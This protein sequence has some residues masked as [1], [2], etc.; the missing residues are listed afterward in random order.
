MRKCLYA[1]LVLA[2]WRNSPA[3]EILP[4]GHRPVP[5]GVH[6]FTGAR[7]VVKPGEVIEE[8]TLVIRDGFVAAVGK[9]LTPPADARVWNMKG[10]TIYAGLIDPF[11]TMAGSNP[12]VSTA[13]SEP[14]DEEADRALTSGAGL[15]FFGV[16]G[17]EADPG[18]R[19]PG[20]QLES[21]QPQRRVAETYT[22]NARVLE[23]MHELGFTAANIVPESGIVRGQSALVALSPM[24]PNEALIKAD[25]FQHVAFSSDEGREAGYPRS[26]M[27]A[28]AAIRQVMFD[29]DFYAKDQEHYRQQ[30]NGRKRPT[31]NP[32]LEA[33]AP[34]ITKRMPVVLEGGSVLM[35]YR[36]TQLAADLNLDRIILASGQEWRR[37]DLFQGSRDSFIVP[38]HF[39]E[40][41]KLPEEDDWDQVS[42]DQLRAWDWGPSNPSLLRKQKRDIALTTYGL[43][44]KKQF[45][46][47]LRLVVDRGLSEDDALAALTTIPARL[48]G[49]DKQLGT[50]EAGKIA[51][52]TIV[53]GTNYFQPD[54]RIRE[55]WIDGRMYPNKPA[56]VADKDRGD[57]D[58]GDKDKAE[59]AEKKPTATN[60][61][62]TLKTDPKS[63]LIRSERLAR[64]PLEGRGPFA[65]PPA[66]LVKGATV[67][68][69]GPQGILAD[70]DVIFAGGRI[71]AI[72]KNLSSDGVVIDGKGKHVT[73]GLLDAHNHSMIL[74][75]VNEGSLPS[76]AMVRVQ[77]V[78]NSETANI[79]RQLAGGLTIANLLH[80]SAN[81]IGGQ[82]CIIKLRD[83]ASPDEL[84]FAEAPPGIKFA[85]GENVKQSSSERSTRFPRSRMGVG[86][87][88][89]NRFAAAQQY[90]EE[91]ANANGR[92]VRRDLE[93]ETLGEILKGKRWIHCHSYRQD[94]ILAFLRVMEGFNV[95]VGTLQHVLEGYKVADEIAQHGAGASCFADWWAYKYEVI[96]AIPYAGSLMRDRGV[97]VSFN[98]DSSDHARRLYL[99]AAKAVKYGGTTEEEALKFVTINPA[100]QLRIDQR[101]GSLEVGKDADFVLWS[102]SPLD[103]KTV[104]LQTWIDGRKFFDREENV[105]RVAALEKERDDLIDKAKQIL[106]NPGR[107]GGASDPKAEASFFQ[108]ALEYQH[109]FHDRHCLDEED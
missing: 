33:L 103:A 35:S 109:D 3:A 76:T 29:A 62:D 63:R 41:A 81:P 10:L 14:I 94:E 104:C 15:N 73:P 69:C 98:S 77:D 31:F 28:I 106:K 70:T 102:A 43:G 61:V 60:Q 34:A 5:P 18:G 39:P 107:S 84:K 8:G 59:T 1:F 6:A 99:E 30:P 55:V 32:A 68:T 13:R 96:D 16:P 22:P 92:P 50:L 97:L 85:L 26:L 56:A 90:L 101:V 45:R 24:N 74:G 19:G 47:K 71:T 89:A 44:D 95:K 91:I 11:L 88:I 48:C 66:I 25:V 75:A 65:T 79:H 64:A 42:L 83:G 82:N 105:A 7:V 27:G 53:D 108:V 36:A 23:V 72:G 87:F 57:R 100:K 58:K 37:P 40:L 17:E 12:P 80:G 51:N 4:P 38:V 49:V 78:V 67:W 2:L 54:A 52:L 20:Y 93:L 46:K 9:D 21:I 86:T